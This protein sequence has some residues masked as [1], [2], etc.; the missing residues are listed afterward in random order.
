VACP[1]VGSRLPGQSEV[2]QALVG[3]YS[4]SSQLEVQQRSC[5]YGRTFLH[6]AIRPQLFEHMPALDESTY[7]A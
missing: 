5:E 7:A 6:N 3:K 1:Q 2:V 4:S